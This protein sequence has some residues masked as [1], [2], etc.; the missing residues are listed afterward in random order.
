[1]RP[2][3][4]NTAKRINCIGIKV[5]A[6]LSSAAS[7]THSEV[8][9]GDLH[10]HWKDPNA[11]GIVFSVYCTVYRGVEVVQSINPFNGIRD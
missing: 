11:S 10:I 3:N 2:G 1:V 5:Y 6:S 8:E 4:C 9:D 7:Y